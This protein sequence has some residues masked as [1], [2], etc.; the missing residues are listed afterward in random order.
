[1]TENARELPL[2]C[3]LFNDFTEMGDANGWTVL[4]ITLLSAEEV[5]FASGGMVFE[6]DLA[7]VRHARRCDEALEKV[8]QI[9]AKHNLRVEAPDDLA[10]KAVGR[11]LLITES[12]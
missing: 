1:M 12:H 8:R 10:G 6:V 2:E 7:R 4:A 11:C 3:R 5:V 9:A